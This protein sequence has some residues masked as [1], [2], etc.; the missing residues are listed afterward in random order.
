[1]TNILRN[2]KIKAENLSKN[3]YLYIRQSTMKQ[4][5]EHTESTKRQ[6]ALKDKIVAIGWDSSS[7]ITI[8]DDQGLSGAD[9]QSRKGFKYLV[10]EVANGNAG[11]IAG[12]EVSRLARSSSEWNRLLEISVLTNTLIMDEDGIYDISDFNDR[13]LLGLKGTMSEAELHYLKSRMRGGLLNKARR[14]ELK[15]PL[16]IGFVYDEQDEIVKDPDL[17]IQEAI[18]IFFKIFKRTGA[19]WAT[20]REFNRLGYKFPK[21]GG[22]GIEKGT[23]MWTQLVNSRALQTIHNPHY[24][25][26]YFYGERQ[27]K[28]SIDGKREILMPREKWHVFLPD[29]HS[30]YI[31][32]E[33]FE[34]NQKI[35]KTNSQSRKG[36]ERNS[37]PREGSAL[38][39]GIV[40]CGKCGNKMTIRY[41]SKENCMFPQYI[42][43]KRSVEHGEKV[44][45]SIN[46]KGVDEK[47]SSI[48]LDTVTPFA[49]EVSISVQEEL[50]KRQKE[51]EQMY[52]QNIERAKY[53]AEMSKRR[54]MNVDPDNRL[55]ASSLEAD[56][57]AAIKRLREAED[58]YQKECRREKENIDLK[59]RNEVVKIANDFPYIWNDPNVADREKKRIVRLLVEDVTLFQDYKNID[60]KIR[61]RGGA[62][63]EVSILR[64]LKIFEKCRTDAKVIKEIDKLLD[65]YT[66]A[67]I[68][69]ILNNKNYISGKGEAFSRKTVGR[70]IRTYNLE[71]RYTRLRQKGLYTLKEIMVKLSASQKEI[72]KL[73][74]RSG[75]KFYKYSDKNEYLYELPEK[76]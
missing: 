42:C 52:L 34:E 35:L 66:T 51:V 67:E 45:Q 28:N 69:D 62:T 60:I 10:S 63:K 57:N 61:F 59:T 12:I 36:S 2:E 75:I 4:V 25:G 68:A 11:I 53:E 13:L 64:P 41:H 9:S 58:A 19:A 29:A 8:D 21:K 56:W 20:V 3:A 38:I 44:C 72:Q 17:Q 15:V 54:Y 46:G 31:S 43:Q 6:Y 71:T 33:E 70:I 39:Q 7:V 74:D 16:P 24:A 48:L 1:L 18:N 65:K 26:V 55:V 22:K 47:I 14:G 50:I 49:M 37:P 23:L 73:R 32:L 40:I 76:I 5:Y 27:V 30:A